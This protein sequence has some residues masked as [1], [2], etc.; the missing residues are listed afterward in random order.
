MMKGFF[1][2]PQAT[3]EV[4]RDGWLYTGDL[5]RIDEDGYLFLTGLKKNMI[6]LKGQN[7]YPTDIEGVLS[8][9]PKVTKAVVVGI[10]DHDGYFI[11]LSLDYVPGTEDGPIR[12]FKIQAV[13]VGFVVKSR[14]GWPSR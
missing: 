7:I 4:I 13:P 5:G 9:H 14:Q 11:G 12:I 6:I 1:N 3:A 10:P 8:T 2:N